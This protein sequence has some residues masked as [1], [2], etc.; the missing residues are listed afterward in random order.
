MSGGGGGAS[1]GGTVGWAGWLGWTGSAGWGGVS[2]GGVSG[3]GTSCMKSD[4]FM[5]ITPSR[6]SGCLS[7]S[8]LPPR[9]SLL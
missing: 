2:G 1:A 7:A 3:L 8:R 5:T 6:P 9:R 4:S